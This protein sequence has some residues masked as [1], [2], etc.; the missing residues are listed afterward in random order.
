MLSSFVALLEAGFSNGLLRSSLRPLYLLGQ[1]FLGPPPLRQIPRVDGAHDDRL[2][3]RLVAVVGLRDGPGLWRQGGGAAAAV[4]LVTAPTEAHDSG[5]GTSS[6][7]EECSF[8]CC[9]C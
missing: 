4:L 2:P 3:P 1:G 9:G 5:S 8:C 6:R 7:R